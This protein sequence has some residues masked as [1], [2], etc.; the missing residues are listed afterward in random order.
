M[1]TFSLGPGIVDPDPHCFGQPDPG[2][3]G[4]KLPTNTE[5]VKKFHV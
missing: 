4:Q 1:T 2:S 3:G 5:K